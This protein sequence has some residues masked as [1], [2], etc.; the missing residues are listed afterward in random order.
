MADEVKVQPF[1]P[2]PD[3]PLQTPEDILKDEPRILMNFPRPVVLNLPGYNGRVR[4]GAGPQSVPQSLVKHE[5]L[6][7]NGA[8]VVEGSM[9][10]PLDQF[11]VDDAVLEVLR[12]GDFLVASKEQAE[13]LVRS[14]GPKMRNEFFREIAGHRAAKAAEK[15]NRS[16]PKPGGSSL[17]YRPVPVR[18]PITP[19]APAPAKA[20]GGK[21]AA[22]K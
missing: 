5:W 21:S 15:L 8:A 16:A 7:A 4:F 2:R 11:I 19:R 9:P 13:A 18:V 17:S 1:A 20:N 22:K 14:F 12:E 6:V 3:V 10:A